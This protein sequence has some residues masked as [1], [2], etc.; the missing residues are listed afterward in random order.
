MKKVI[1]ACI[2][3]YLLLTVWIYTAF[4]YRD[5]IRSGD[6]ISRYMNM[7]IYILIALF[8]I[9][10]FILYKYRSEWLKKI[11]LS[12]FLLIL[13]LVGLS[14]AAFIYLAEMSLSQGSLPIGI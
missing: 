13:F 3:P 7:Y 6:N 8:L 2:S 1:L 5:H 14:F 4:H 10:I 11:Y 12:I 9:D